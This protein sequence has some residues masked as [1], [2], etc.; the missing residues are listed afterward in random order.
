MALE[1][2]AMNAGFCGANGINVGAMG[3]NPAGQVNVGGTGYQHPQG[4]MMGGGIPISGGAANMATEGH[5]INTNGF[6]GGLGGGGVAF[7]AILL[8]Y[9]HAFGLGLGF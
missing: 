9:Q 5:G 3:Y 8:N 6:G 2:Q 4:G 7:G 1:D